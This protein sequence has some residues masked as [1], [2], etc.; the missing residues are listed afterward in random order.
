MKA[1]ALLAPVLA[2][3]GCTSGGLEASSVLEGSFE[4]DDGLVVRGARLTVAPADARATDA[5]FGE[6][7]E[8][9]RAQTRL[10]R[11]HWVLEVR[12]EAPEPAAQ[13]RALDLRLEWQGAPAGEVRLHQRAGEAGAAVASFDVG[14]ELPRTALYLLEGRWA[15]GAGADAAPGK[16][17]NTG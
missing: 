1:L 16:S 13:G 9:G 14:P 15:D 2:L 3:A 4:L 12:L 10:R 7:D 5:A 6:G 8:P 17:T 11:D